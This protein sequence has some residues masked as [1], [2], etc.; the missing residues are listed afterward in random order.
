M[1]LLNS[2]IR[3]KYLFQNIMG[4]AAELGTKKHRVQEA[5]WVFCLNLRVEMEIDVDSA[6]FYE[7]KKC[8]MEPGVY[9]GGVYLEIWK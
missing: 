8:P 2:D 7:T 5:T 4:S 6:R 1:A 9:Y 3:L